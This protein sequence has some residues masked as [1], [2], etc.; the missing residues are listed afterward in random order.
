MQSIFKS[1]KIKFYFD[2]LFVVHFSIY[3]LT[4]H[5]YTHVPFTIFCHFS[6]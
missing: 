5:I 3:I 4:L 1:F 6:T 2:L